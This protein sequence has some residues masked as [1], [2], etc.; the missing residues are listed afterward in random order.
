LTSWPAFTQ[1]VLVFGAFACGALAFRLRNASNEFLAAIAA[2]SGA[3]AALTILA[4]LDADPSM[5]LERGHDWLLVQAITCVPLAALVLVVSRMNGW[6]FVQGSGQYSYTMYIAHFPLFLFMYFWLF[7][8]FPVMLE[9]RWAALTACLG[10]TAAWCMLS[11]LGRWIEQP[12]AQRAM[13]VQLLLGLCRSSV[14]QWSRVLRKVRALA[15]NSAWE[16]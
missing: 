11:R 4:A 5:D 15:A 6:R 2:A 9:P 12:S 10:V 14:R 13:A 7:H 16:R 1:Q 8:A 3:A